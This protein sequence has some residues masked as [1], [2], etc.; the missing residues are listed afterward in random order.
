MTSRTIVT[1][2]AVAKLL[3]HKSL[4]MTMRYSHLSPQH[5]RVAVERLG[6]YNS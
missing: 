5:K 2:I 4:T 3:G 1:L 6:R